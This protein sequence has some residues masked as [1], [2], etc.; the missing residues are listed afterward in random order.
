[1]TQ[2]RT[3][4]LTRLSDMFNGEIGR[5]E[6]GGKMFI[7]TEVLAKGAAR[8]GEVANERTDILCSVKPSPR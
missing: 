8:V 7:G 6:G 4:L 2:Q 1:M 5:G 3:S